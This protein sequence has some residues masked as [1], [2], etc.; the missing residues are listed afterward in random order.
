L[1]YRTIL[2]YSII[3]LLYIKRSNK[4][5]IYRTVNVILNR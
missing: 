1:I 2:K 4:P 5:L 3:D